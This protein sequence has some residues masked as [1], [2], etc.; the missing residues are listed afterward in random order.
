MAGHPKGLA[1]CLCS[2]E[3]NGRRESSFISDG[4]EY[5]LGNNTFKHDPSGILSCSVPLPQKEP[6]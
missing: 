5:N 4:S 6:S 2:R 3:D 1:Q